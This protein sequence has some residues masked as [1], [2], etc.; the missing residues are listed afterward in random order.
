[1]CCYCY[2]YHDIWKELLPVIGD[3]RELKLTFEILTSQ[4]QT[5]Q[6]RLSQLGSR[7]ITIQD[8]FYDMPTVLEYIN[9]SLNMSSDVVAALLNSGIRNPGGMYELVG[10]LLS[11]SDPWGAACNLT[12][13][14]L[15]QILDLPENVD[16]NRIWTQVCDDNLTAITSEVYSAFRIDSIL[17]SLERAVNQSNPDSSLEELSEALPGLMEGL[18]QLVQESFVNSTFETPMIDIDHLNRMIANTLANTTVDEMDIAIRITESLLKSVYSDEV[19][20]SVRPVFSVNYILIKYFQQLVD[21]ISI[22]NQKI[23]IGA[24]FRNATQWRQLLGG[25]VNVSGD[26]LD[27]ITNISVNLDQVGS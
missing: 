15:K 20:A 21:K 18:V 8:L 1:M 27:H 11:Q 7:K 16:I 26:L 23:E 14:D 12:S 25:A 5:L 19:F 13:V 4:I 24:L 6:T 10:Q 2:R 17:A 3:N 9:T 22:H